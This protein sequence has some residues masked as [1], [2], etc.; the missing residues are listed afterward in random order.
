MSVTT[1]DIKFYK[2]GPNNLGGV[3][4]TAT[5]IPSGQL[6]ALF[7]AVRAAEALA[8]STDYRCIYIRNEAAGAAPGSTLTD[9]VAYIETP[10]SSPGVT[11]TIGKGTAAVGGQEP[12]IPNEGTAPIG[13]T[14]QVADAP[15]NS[16]D[17]DTLLSN[18]HQAI[19]IKRVVAPNTQA[20]AS[21]QFTLT[22]LGETV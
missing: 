14:F 5:Q 22:I 17:L 13:V 12:I 11:I 7:D 9:P 16:L 2:S 20:M 19:W 3:I 18:Q 10:P 8:G 1:N 6:H 15:L 4:D 21:D